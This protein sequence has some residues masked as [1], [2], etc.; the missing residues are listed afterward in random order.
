M[1]F[2]V[3]GGALSTGLVGAELHRTKRRQDKLRLTASWQPGAFG[4]V[5]H[6]RF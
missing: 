4:L 3:A 2:L 6:G 1:G 5:A